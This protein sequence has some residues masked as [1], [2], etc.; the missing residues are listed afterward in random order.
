MVSSLV[1]NLKAVTFDVWNTLLVAKSYAPVRIEYLAKILKRNNIIKSIKEISNAYQYSYD[2][3]EQVRQ[4]GNY[5]FIKVG[6][7]LD[8]ILQK[9]R[10]ELSTEEKTA[11]MKY[12]E[13]VTLT[14]SPPLVEGTEEILSLLKSRYQIG[15]ICGSG[16]TPGRVLRTVLQ[17]KGILK[18][19][20]SQVF[21]D[22]VGY[23]KPHHAI[24]EKSLKEL[25]VKPA[26][27]IHIGDLLDT[28]VAGAKAFGMRTVWYNY[29]GK[30][31]DM[32]FKPDW[33]IRR[34]IQLAEY[35]APGAWKPKKYMHRY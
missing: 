11:A 13:G 16:L 12:F 2:F 22:E 25:K 18:Y 30:L 3:A 21:S 14:D 26:Q 33:E 29:E 7:R 32:P 4:E 10:S 28:D 34:L 8:Y 27:A 19:F 24:F 5:R 17:K 23:E 31:N 35:L 20:E 1:K 6:E 9:L 15:I